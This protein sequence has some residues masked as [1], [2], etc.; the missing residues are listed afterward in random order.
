MIALE[1]WIPPL[2]NSSLTGIL[3]FLFPLKDGLICKQ[4]SPQNTSMSTLSPQPGMSPSLSS[5]Y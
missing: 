2:K 3:S 5:T 1:E 4:L